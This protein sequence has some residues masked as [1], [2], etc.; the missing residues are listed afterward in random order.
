MNLMRGQTQQFFDKIPETTDF[1]LLQQSQ[2]RA[3]F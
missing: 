2:N 1:D 3:K